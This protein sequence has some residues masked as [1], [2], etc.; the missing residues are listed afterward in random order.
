MVGRALAERAPVWT[1]DVLNDPRIQL[2][3]ESR[4]WIEEIGGRSILA[5]PLVREHL[6]GALVVYRPVGESFTSSAP[7]SPDMM[8]LVSWKLRAAK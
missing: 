1:A 6:T 7:P 2:R 8:F 4:R 5:V 3:P